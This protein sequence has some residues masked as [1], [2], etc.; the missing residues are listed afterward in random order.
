MNIISNDCTAGFIYRE[1]NEEFKNPFIW[2]SI[3]ID[4]FIKLIENYDTLNFNNISIKL[5]LNTSKISVQNEKYPIITIDNKVDIH[6]FHHFQKEGT[7]SELN[8]E[9][10]YI[11]DEDI[12]NYVKQIY[13]SRISRMT[14]SPIFIWSNFEEYSWYNSKD[15]EK[16]KNVS[17]KYK[18]IIYSNSSIKNF[19]KDILI[20][21]KPFSENLV[22]K[23]AI[24]LSDY[25]K[26]TLIYTC[27]DEKYSHFIPLFCAAL[28]YS[29]KNIDIEIGTSVNKLTD[30]EEKALTY[31]RS[32]FPTSKILIKY[33]YF[34]VNER[35]TAI[36]NN[37]NM[38]INTV[39]FVSEPIIKNY[40]TYI[41]DIDLIMFDEDFYISHL[42]MFK[43]YNMSYSNIVRKNTP[44]HLSGLHFCISKYWYPLNLTNINC[45]IN[46]EEVLMNIA[47]TKTNINTELTFRPQH[48][49]HMSFNRPEVKA[50]KIIGWGA[51]PYKNIWNKFIDTELYKTIKPSFNT[52][53]SEQIYKLNNF[54][55]T[56][57]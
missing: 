38:A 10:R 51:E 57:I 1:I 2:T 16:L 7:H 28:L 25:F 48:G 50:G 36:Y 23:N 21:K 34:K 52:I 43:K 44:T 39:R 20:I 53:I 30:A 12:I 37:K 47:K 41:S 35:N 17:T 8:T 19:S 56:I 4:N 6:Y 3:D 24:S 18:L 33:N 14:E 29:N 11:Y 15:I 31:L 40:Y 5:E 27:C 45:N 54:Y 32:S 46:D 26:R 42:E 55:K 9:E 49:I 13:F 22:E